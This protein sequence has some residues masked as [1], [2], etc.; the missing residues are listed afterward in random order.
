MRRSLIGWICLLVAIACARNGVAGSEMSVRIRNLGAPASYNMTFV[1]SWHDDKGGFWVPLGCLVKGGFVKEGPLEKRQL[2]SGEDSGW[3]PLPAFGS[4]LRI[5]RAGEKPW[6]AEVELSLQGEGATQKLSRTILWEG[7]ESALHV[8]TL[9]LPSALKGEEFCLKTADELLQ[10][11]GQVVQQ[12]EQE[13]PWKK[14]P[15]RLVFYTNLPTEAGED[16][17]IVGRQLEFLRKIGINGLASLDPVFGSQATQKGIPFL[18][19][20]GAGI[21]DI[22]KFEDPEAF[23]SLCRNLALAVAG[24][25]ERYGLQSKVRMQMIGDEVSCGLLQDYLAAGEKTRAHLTNWLT[26]LGV[27]PSEFGWKDYSQLQIAPAGILKQSNPALYY[28]A[29]RVFMEQSIERYKFCDEANARYFPNAWASPNWAISGV[30]LG[31]YDSTGYDGWLLYRRKALRG[32]WGEDW[33]GYSWMMQ[34]AA[35]FQS[36]LMRSQSKDLPLGMYVVVEWGYTPLAAHLKF[37]EELARGFSQFFWFSYG[38]LNGN[39]ANPWATKRDMVRE[40]AL[41]HREAAEAEPYLLDTRLEPA[42]VAVLW[43]PAQEIWASGLHPNLMALHHLLLHSNYAFDILSSYDVDDGIL[44]RYQVLYMPF[45]FIE[46]RT[47]MA[48]KGWVERGGSLVIEGGVLSDEYNRPIQL[49]EWLP[50]YRA[51]VVTKDRAINSLSGL[52]NNARLDETKPVTFPVVFSKAVLTAPA[53]AQETLTYSE[54]RTAAF[55]LVRGK[56]RVTVYGFHPGLSYIWEEGRKDK[57]KGPF[58]QTAYHW[59]NPVL[60]EQATAPIA[61]AGIPHVCGI[62][63][64]MVVAV[65]RSGGGRECVALFDYHFGNPPERSFEPAWDEVKE[66]RVKVQLSSPADKARSLRG[67]ITARKGNTV[68]V[69]F[70]GVDMILA[71]E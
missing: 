13:C 54:G 29:S 34:G 40:I 45:E 2:Q 69:V 27:P 35:A 32:N 28:W 21:Q 41:M 24:V 7:D 49:G 5:R 14:R 64:D 16:P 50:G 39:E 52:H 60:R 23:R 11:N 44:D 58:G 56:G 38:G 20:S 46:K 55:A 12:V 67:N 3:T 53:G 18:M 9:L 30:Q 71:D 42:K 48:V 25:H 47:W 22:F 36:D 57:I 43:T 1:R 37:Y 6:R 15:E 17:A 62:N 70:R 4:L 33:P 31:G 10:E 26:K 66:R 59:F 65:R 61:G 19:S 63:D 51:E 68:E 8:Y